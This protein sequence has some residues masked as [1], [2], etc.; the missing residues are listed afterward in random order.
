MYLCINLMYWIN[1]LP[2]YTIQHC[3][4]VLVL[5]PGIVGTNHFVVSWDR[6]D[7]P[8]SPNEFTFAIGEEDRPLPATPVEPLLCNGTLTCDADAP[9]CKLR[10]TDKCGD[11]GSCRIKTVT[12]TANGVSS[13]VLRI[14]T[15]NLQALSPHAT[16]HVTH[17][18]YTVMM[19][20]IQSQSSRIL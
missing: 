19:V 16:L 9:T 10:T 15:G 18:L 20:T 4:T 5:T 6:R 2:P 3:V 17:Q 13:K 11:L 14:E 8:D 12:V 1:T 7:W